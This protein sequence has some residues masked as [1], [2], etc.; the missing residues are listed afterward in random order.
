M[1]LAFLKIGAAATEVVAAPPLGEVF[2]SLKFFLFQICSLVA[3]S[4][5]SGLGLQLR[6]PAESPE[7]VLWAPGS[8]RAALFWRPPSQSGAEK[9]WIKPWE[10]AVGAREYKNSPIWRPLG[11]FEAVELV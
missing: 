4:E 2:V 3:C 6:D 9:S 10:S 11:Q 1:I 8:M 7:D 5:S